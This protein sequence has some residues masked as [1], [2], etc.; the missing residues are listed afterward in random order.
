MLSIYIFLNKFNLI[1]LSYSI[2]NIIKKILP[3]LGAGRIIL[4]INLKT[5][6]NLKSKIKNFDKDFS[7][8]LFPIWLVIN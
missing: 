5:F 1:K 8:T 6:F 7:L 3:R 2:T 4:D